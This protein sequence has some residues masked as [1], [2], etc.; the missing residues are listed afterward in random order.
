MTEFTKGPWIV[1]Q[2]TVYFDECVKFSDR[3]QS[4][5]GVDIAPKLGL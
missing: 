2:E 3:V 1:R 5:D 4:Q